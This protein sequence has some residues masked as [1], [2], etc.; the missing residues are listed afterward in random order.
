MTDFYSGQRMD[1]TL[2]AVKN[3]LNLLNL[4]EKSL[5]PGFKV[6]G[7]SELKFTTREEAEKW[8]LKGNNRIEEIRSRIQDNA[9]SWQK[10]RLFMD[11]RR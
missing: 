11:L 9:S 1:S 10:E 8:I 7:F 6:K 2:I 5:D 4:L 3:R